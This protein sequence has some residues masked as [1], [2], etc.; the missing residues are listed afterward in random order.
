METMHSVGISN[1]FDALGSLRFKG[2]NHGNAAMDSAVY[3]AAQA[4]ASISTIMARL[5]LDLNMHFDADHLVHSRKR[6][7]NRHLHGDFVLHW[8]AL[9]AFFLYLVYKE[10]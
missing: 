9:F 7:V 8:L 2:V 1:P 4:K 5:N 3:G 6:E 10:T